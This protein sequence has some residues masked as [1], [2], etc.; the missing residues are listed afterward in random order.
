MQGEPEDF[1]GKLAH[2]GEENAAWHPLNHHC[3]DVAACCEALLS[4]TLLGER[5]AALGA[6]KALPKEWILR[7]CVL[8]AWHDLGKFNTGFQNKGWKRSPMAGHIKEI[9]VL[10]E[11]SGA[12]QNELCKVLPLEEIQNWADGETTFELLLASLSHHGQ[13][14]NTHDRPPARAVWQSCPHTKRNPFAGM[15]TLIADSKSWFPEAFGPVTIALPSSA[16]FQHLFTGIVMLADWLGSDTRFFPF[17][18]TTDDRMAFAR[19]QAE[20]ALKSIGLSCS[21]ARERQ[22]KIV[23]TYERSFG[24]AE[25][26]DMQVRAGE[27]PIGEGPSLAILESET[28][29]GKTEAAYWHFLR[30][31]RAGEVDGMYFA[32]PTRTAAT[33]VYRRL[34]E[35]TRRSFPDESSRPP[36]VLAV[37]GY[38]CV[39]DVEACRLPGFE[40]LWN[41]DDKERMRY[42]AWA[43][44]APKR[45]LA[46]GI[47]VGTIDQ[48]LLSTLAVSHAHLR[49]SALSRQLLVV[50]EVHASDT[51]MTTLLE[52]VLKSHLQTHGHAFLM[53]ATLGQE[54]A[55][56][57]R[58]ILDPSHLTPSLGDAQLAAFPVICGQNAQATTVISASSAILAKSVQIEEQRIAESVTDIAALAVA[59][60]SQGASVLVLRNTVADCRETQRAIEAINDSYLMRC[61]K[62]C[63]PHHSRYAKEDRMALDKAI[64]EAFG[65]ARSQ[66]GRIVV[67]TQT[68]QQSLDLD[69][70]Y[71]IT[72]LCPVDVL[73]QRIGR[74]HRHTR[75][76]PASFEKPRCTVLVPSERDLC[77]RIRASGESRG[78]LGLGSVYE[79]LR[80]LEATWRLVS[81][82]PCWDIPENN[83]EL[84]ELATH[85][86]AL[87]AIAE[88]LGEPMQAHAQWLYGQE[89]SCRRIAEG[90]LVA[91]DACF[92]T[93]QSRFPSKELAGRIST[94]LGADD[95]IA[96][97]PAPM[98]GVFGTTI[99]QFT[100]PI[101]WLRSGA[102]ADE[103]P[104]VTSSSDSQLRFT[105]GGESFRYDRLGLYREE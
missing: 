80:V 68:V 71:L 93:E 24:F 84:V 36:V 85:P 42:R 37:P 40:V 28:G 76:R 25:P 47:A 20:L 102:A 92:G 70:D 21:E 66:R 94:R 17:S 103:T 56:R 79:D 88:E 52:S 59:S 41:D 78:S 98:S 89:G 14:V 57:Y 61:G 48:V 35:A 55:G 100:I 46:A 44:E 67:A 30:L 31:F 73:L 53:S 65:K 96:I 90:H 64:E 77:T 10:F 99:R 91:R 4:T 3:A 86:E 87:A 62:I 83:R 101:Y 33:Q 63:A 74:L 50:D 6:R 95:R 23:A 7:L 5:L 60:A 27:V 2:L 16:E 105:F 12:A 82:R 81:E 58:R 75:S 45:Y 69:A 15:T 19:K 13:P 1:W 8:C 43:A 38:I 9:A 104:V 22:N 39:D 34:V 72:D 49:A 54:L 97:L 18:E 26:R 29:S 11:Y 32:L 51:Y